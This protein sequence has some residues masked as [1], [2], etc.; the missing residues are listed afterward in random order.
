MKETNRGKPQPQS[1]SRVV[2]QAGGSEFA[3]KRGLSFPAKSAGARPT[4]RENGLRVGAR[5]TANLRAALSHQ[6]S[7]SHDD[8]A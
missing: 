8:D 7:F 3:V 4:A 6:K 1:T 5:S 2:E